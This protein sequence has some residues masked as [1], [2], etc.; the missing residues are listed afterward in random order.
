MLRS[1]E[2]CG[3][4]KQFSRVTCAHQLAGTHISSVLHLLDYGQTSVT[5]NTIVA[6]QLYA[7]ILKPKTP[8]RTRNHNSSWPDFMDAGE[9]APLLVLELTDRGRARAR[10]DCRWISCRARVFVSYR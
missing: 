10:R 7:F 1:D 2:C 5:L 6:P 8:S 3:L 9:Y 4:K